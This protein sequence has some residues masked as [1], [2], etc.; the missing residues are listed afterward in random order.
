MARIDYY[1]IEE[2]IQ[3]ILKADPSLAGINVLIEEDLSL[4]DADQVGIYLDRRDAPEE[5]QRIAAGKRT[6][7][8]LFFSIVARAFN[9]NSLSTVITASR[10][11]AP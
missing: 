4:S 10:G 7:Y 8:T 3:T 9:L 1:A 5:N 11:F 2:E 6:D